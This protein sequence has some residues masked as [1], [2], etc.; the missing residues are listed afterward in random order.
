MPNEPFVVQQTIF[1]ESF[2]PIRVL[3]CGEYALTQVILD[4]FLDT[5]H[6][7][8]IGVAPLYGARCTL[9][10]LAFSTMSQV[11]LVRLSSSKKKSRSSSHKL[12]RS[13]L[14]CHTGRL[15][16]AFKMDKL[17]TSLF[18]DFD[19]RITDGVCLL[20]PSGSGRDFAQSILTTLG[21]DTT[22]HKN[23]VFKLFKHDENVP[24][25]E[26]D[27]AL[28]AWTAYRAAT[29]VSTNSTL[30]GLPRINTRVLPEAV[31]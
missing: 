10:V 31:R 16:C 7:N 12:L 30:S 2:P 14:L 17:A 20:S 21:E 19:L 3:P 22:L 5:A 11:L 9:T 28:Q 4:N 8:Y 18:L 13:R 29:L 1:R 25:T 26:Q 15:K 24:T 23:N 27:V 6:D